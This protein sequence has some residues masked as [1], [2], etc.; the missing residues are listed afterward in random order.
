MKLYEISPILSIGFIGFRYFF[1]KKIVKF[2]LALN[3][4]FAMSL[5]PNRNSRKLNFFAGF[6]LSKKCDTIFLW[7]LNFS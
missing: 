1:L 6:Y 7:I 2:P 4:N 3:K 5:V